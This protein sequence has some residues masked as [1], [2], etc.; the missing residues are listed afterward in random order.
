MAITFIYREKH[1][2]L[3]YSWYNKLSAVRTSVQMPPDPLVGLTAK[4]YLGPKGPEVLGNQDGN[5]IVCRKPVVL[6]HRGPTASLVCSSRHTINRR[7]HQRSF[8]G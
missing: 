5:K 7:T 8:Y 3:C 4:I 6:Y 1:S 2:I